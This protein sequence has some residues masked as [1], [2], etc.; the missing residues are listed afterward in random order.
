MDAK[1][2]TFGERFLDELR[3][4]SGSVGSMTYSQIQSIREADREG[5]VRMYRGAYDYRTVQKMKTLGP[6]ELAAEVFRQQREA[7]FAAAAAS[8]LSWLPLVF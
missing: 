6:E 4:L 7:A 8:L 2:G 5:L 3:R 1:E